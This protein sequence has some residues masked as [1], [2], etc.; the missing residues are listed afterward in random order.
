[1]TSGTYDLCVAYRI[2]PRISRNP[3]IFSESK[4]QLSDFCLDSFKN[5]LGPL[6]VKMIVLLDKC[7]PEYEAMFRKYFKDEDL[8]FHHLDGIG[9][10]ATFSMQGDLLLAQEFSDVVFFAEDDYYYRP[11]QFGEMVELLY[12]NP[13][14]DFISPY[15]HPDDYAYSPCFSCKPLAFFLDRYW[16]RTG[17]TCLTF[18]TTKETLE[19]TKNVFLTYSRGNCDAGVWFALTKYHVL[20]PLS[21]VE[22]LLIAPRFVKFILLSWRYNWRQILFGKKY[23]LWVPIPSI[24]THME[25]SY[26]APG[27][28]KE[29]EDIQKM[30]GGN[31]N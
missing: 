5:S 22:F 25:S 9:N 16:K 4:I 21:I 23:R 12:N 15:D 3:P 19:K 7:P 17:S 6:K 31:K 30:S 18:L 2:Y 10:L 24:G 28:R 29:L 20:N 8:V 26:L 11:G 27:F 13:D 14:V 1:M